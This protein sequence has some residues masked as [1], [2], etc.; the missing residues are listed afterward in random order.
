MQY[1]LTQDE[2]D[3]L[4]RAQ[5]VLATDKKADLQK[6]CTDAANHIPVSPPWAQQSTPEPWGCILNE[7]V[8]IRAAYCDHCPAR[9]VCPYDYKE[10]SQ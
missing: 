1:I 2:Y 7:G 3:E 4:R 5:D 10:W 6:L 9:H 8:R